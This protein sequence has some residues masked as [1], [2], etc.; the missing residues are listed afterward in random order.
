M[1]RITDL[2]NKYI[3]IYKKNGIYTISWD[4]VE[5]EEESGDTI[6]ASWTYEKFSDLPSLEY[7]KQMIND[8][9]NKQTDYK[10]VS[11]FKWKEKSVWLSSE[12][13]FN[14]KAAYD[15]AKQTDG[16]NLPVMFKIGEEDGDPI[17]YTFETIEELQEFYL[18]AMNHI[19]QCLEDGWKKKDSIDWSVYETITEA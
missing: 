6:I 17:Y 3:P 7:I 12:N 10:I 2:K 18:A 1:V 15:L 9:Y 16:A 8:Y 11:G 19:Q 14:F 4:Y 13:Q 5:I